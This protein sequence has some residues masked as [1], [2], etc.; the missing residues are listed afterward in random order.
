MVIKYDKINVVSI[1]LK[2]LVIL[3]SVA[4]IDNAGRFV[5]DV[6]GEGI[7]I[8]YVISAVPV[9]LRAHGNLKLGVVVTDNLAC[10]IINCRK[11]DAASVGVRRSVI[12]RLI[13]VVLCF[14]P[15]NLACRGVNDLN[16][17]LLSATEKT[18]EYTVYTADSIGIVGDSSLILSSRDSSVT[19]SH[20]IYIA[21]E[22]KDVVVVVATERSGG[23]VISLDLLII[24]DS[25]VVSLGL[26][27]V[28]IKVEDGSLAPVTVEC[29]ERSVKVNTVLIGIIK[30]KVTFNIHTVHEGRIE[31]ALIC[32][33]KS[34]GNGNLCGSTCCNGNY[35]VC[36][37]AALNRVLRGV[38]KYVSHFCYVFGIGYRYALGHGN[39]AELV[40]KCLAGNILKV[41]AHGIDTGTSRIITELEL[42]LVDAV[43]VEI[44]GSSSR[45]CDICDTCALLSRRVRITLFVKRDGRSGHSELV[46]KV[47]HLG[48]GK[49]GE[50]LFDVLT[51]KN[52]DTAHVGCRHTRTTHLVVLA[53]YDGRKN[54]STVSCDLRLKSEV[55]VR[56]PG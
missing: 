24:V 11:I 46:N 14:L 48:N 8:R 32:I 2:R 50:C 29:K 53:T 43:N 21:A 6:E 25:I 23:I 31:I 39:V 44:C 5:V 47:S 15:Y 54:V 51:D 3:G 37:S 52:G 27:L 38:R 56:S 55:G 18:C 35:A 33:G 16:V 49:L 4:V 22:R 26:N 12:V 36:K 30:G 10:I 40:R 9:E 45:L 34:D 1:L 41:N 42:G 7:S 20:G 19:G 17:H 13:T 28:V